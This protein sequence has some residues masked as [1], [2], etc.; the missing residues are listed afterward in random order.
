MSLLVHSDWTPQFRDHL[1]TCKNPTGLMN[2]SGFPCAL[3]RAL[4]QENL[5]SLRNRIF[6]ENHGLFLIAQRKLSQ[7][8]TSNQ[9]MCIGLILCLLPYHHAVRCHFSS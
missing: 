7:Q 4:P 9:P 2:F 1:Q 6:T 8:I 3:D 5:K